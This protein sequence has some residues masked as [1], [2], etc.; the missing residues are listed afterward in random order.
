MPDRFGW[1]RDA[2]SPEAP[3]TREST[4]AARSNQPRLDPSM[5]ELAAPVECLSSSPLARAARGVSPIPGSSPES[6][7]PHVSGGAGT[8]P[9]PGPASSEVP[10]ATIAE[11]HRWLRA[12]AQELRRSDAAFATLMAEELGKPA[13]EVTLTELLPVLSSVD[14]LER[15]LASL[16]RPRRFRGGAFWQWGDSVHS[17]R[18]PLG[19]V[20]IIA[21]W[22]YPVQLLGIQLAQSIA[23]GNE[24]WVK[25]SERTPRT[26]R[27]LLSLARRALATAGLSQDLLVECEATREEGPRLL[28]DHRFDHVLFT[29]STEVGRS[30][31]LWAANTLTPTTLELSGQDSAIVLDDADLTLAARSI[32]QAVTMNSGQT[33]MAPRRVLVERGAYAG[34]L[35]ALAP[36]ASAV[37]PH[38]LIDAAAAQRAFAAAADAVGRGAHSLSG[39]IEAPEG[40]S[41]RP[42][43]IV[44]CPRA[45]DLFTGDHFGPVLA[46]VPVEN[47]DEAMRLHQGIGQALAT[48][49]FTRSSERARSAAAAFGSSFVTIND[50][51]RPTSHPSAALGGCGPS[52]WGVSRGIGGLLSL[53]REVTVTERGRFTPP[54]RTPSAS[55]MRWIRRLAGLVAAPA[56]APERLKDLAQGPRP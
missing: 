45:C 9:M 6:A 46:I 25:P 43:A 35:D 50:C 51:V 1:W 49:V 55:V 18:A 37:R 27:H 56:A 16:L 5:S 42:L 44:D 39:V 36:I 20:L 53:T 32:W 31:A 19:R 14:W 47:I 15:S 41:L 10:A 3:R 48:S 30:I 17:T 28:R 13:H 8:S 22:N 4:E 34:F 21:T 24:T 52:G 7:T 2:D 12:F 26:Q 38:R 11:R 40:A 33:C 54:P 29:G 23:A